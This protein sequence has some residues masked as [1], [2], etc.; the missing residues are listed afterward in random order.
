LTELSADKNLQLEFSSEELHKFWLAPRNE[1]PELV[2]EALK[3]LITFAA[4]FLCRMDSLQW[5]Q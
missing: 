5:Q 3:I 4:S 2:T 1:C